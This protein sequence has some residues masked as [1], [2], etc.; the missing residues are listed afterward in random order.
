MMKS[1]ANLAVL[2][3]ELEGRSNDLTEPA[4][5]LAP[6]IRE[7]LAALEAMPGCRLARLSGSGA[8]CFGLFDNPAAAE[9]VA[10]DLEVDGWWVRATRFRT[11]GA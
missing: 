4:L 3:R 5:R 7:V 2:V 1:P 6:V 8:T 10:G 9:A 11:S